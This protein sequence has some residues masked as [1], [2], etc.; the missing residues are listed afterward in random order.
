MRLYWSL[1]AAYLLAVAVFGVLLGG[2]GH[3]P[4]IAVVFFL[5]LPCSLLS[6]LFPEDT[7]MLWIALMGF[8]QWFA[9][10][11]A[12]DWMRF[13]RKR[14]ELSSRLKACLQWVLTAFCLFAVASL[15]SYFLRSTGYGLFQV[16]DGLP[17]FS[18]SAQITTCP[19]KLSPVP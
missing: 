13:R 2:A 8:L 10:G 9:I 14:R 16:N 17:S 6:Y 7:V 12:F 4:G 3:G 19:P 5:S 1:P 18:F 15:G 11:M